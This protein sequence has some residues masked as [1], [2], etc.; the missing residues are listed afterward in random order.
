M[1]IRIKSI[2]LFYQ[3]VNGTVLSTRAGSGGGVA[4]VVRMSWAGYEQTRV[5][6]SKPVK[7]S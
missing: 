3:L 6:A 1:V 4:Q 7:W 5:E 2:N